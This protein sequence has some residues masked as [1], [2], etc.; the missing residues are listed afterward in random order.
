MS[1]QDFDFH[2]FRHYHSAHVDTLQN[3]LFV[4]PVLL[5]SVIAHEYA[6]GYAALRQGDSTALAMGRLTWNPLKHIDPVLTI[7][8]PLIMGL[9]ATSGAA[10]S[11]FPSPA[12]PPTV[13]SPSRRR[14]S[15]RSLA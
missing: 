1:R 11:S 12:S 14:S 7:L 10:T 9:A 4:A 5:F 13:S 8:M 15:L 2:H 3:V 6:H